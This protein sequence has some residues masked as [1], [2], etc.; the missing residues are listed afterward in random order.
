MLKQE[1]QE[2]LDTLKGKN[3]NENYKSKLKVSSESVSRGSKE[4]ELFCECVKKFKSLECT[5]S[6][7]KEDRFKHIDFHIS[8]GMSIDVKAH[9]RINATD[10]KS[11]T[12][13]TWVELMNVNGG[14]GWVDGWASHIVYSFTTH[15]KLFNRKALKKFI[16]S[17]VDIHNVKTKDKNPIPYEVY[18]RGTL[19]DKVVLVPIKDLIDNVPFLELERDEKLL[20]DEE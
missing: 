7:K 19:K 3:M 1:V 4:E 2:I 10:A 13:Y 14:L 6:S 20:E 18:R 17:K 12:E 9:K 5:K 15:Y 16:L 11:S 8:N